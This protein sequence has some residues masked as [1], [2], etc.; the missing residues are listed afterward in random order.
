MSHKEMLKFWEIY[1]EK[2]VFQ[3]SKKPI[4]KNGY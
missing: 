1:I 4:D 2:S 3:V